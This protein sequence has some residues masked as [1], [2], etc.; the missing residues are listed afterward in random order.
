ME[1]DDTIPAVVGCHSRGGPEHAFRHTLSRR[2]LAY[3]LASGG[4]AAPPGMPDWEAVLYQAVGCQLAGLLG[5]EKVLRDCRGVEVNLARQ[6][7]TLH[8]TR[9]GL[10]EAHPGFAEYE[11]FFQA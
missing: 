4:A 8:F 10:A 5:A 1:S 9:G 3:C 2:V 11:F 6:R 7:A